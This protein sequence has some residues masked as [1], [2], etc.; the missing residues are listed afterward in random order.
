MIEGGG[1]LGAE[2]HRYV[3]IWRSIIVKNG[4]FKGVK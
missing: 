1:K 2:Q 4:T 3:S